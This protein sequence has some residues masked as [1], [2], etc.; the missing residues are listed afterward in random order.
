MKEISKT[1]PFF[2]ILVIFFCLSL[3]TKGQILKIDKVNMAADTAGIFS[4]NIGV[5][6]NINNR[7]ATPEEN[8]IYRGLEANVDLSYLSQKHGYLL[9]NKLNYFKITNG[10]LFSTGYVHGRINFLRK[11]RLSYELFSQVQYDDG[12][13]MPLRYLFGGGI[14]FR[15]IQGDKGSLFAGIGIMNEFERWKPFNSE[16]VI[17]KQ[18]WKNTNYLNGNI[19]IS[20]NFKINITTYYQGGYDDES[21]VFRSRLSGDLQ[22]SSKITGKLSFTTNFT[23]LYESDPIIDINPVVYSLTNGLKLNF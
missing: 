16:T 20:E 7:S 10:P 9:L 15:V 1:S 13:R 6:F 18:I 11:N 22:I 5:D 19:I 4:G 17:E 8:L 14:K 12:R 3:T 21:D 2:L 23:L